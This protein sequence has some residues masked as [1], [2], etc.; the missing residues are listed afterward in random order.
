MPLP[1]SNRAW[2]SRRAKRP[3]RFAPRPSR[4]KTRSRKHNNQPRRRVAR[5]DAS[6][7]RRGGRT[8]RGA[9]VEDGRVAAPPPRRTRRGGGRTRRGAVAEDG[10]ARRYDVVVIGSGIGGL[11]CAG[12]LA[13]AGREVCVLEAHYEFGGCAHEFDVDL[14]GRT[15]P[16]ARLAALGADAPP[17]FKFEAGPSLYSGLSPAASPNPLKHIY[18]MIE[19]EPEWITYR[20]PRGTRRARLS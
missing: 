2:L 11:S 16:S 5:T 1:R 20:P 12:L 18:Q 10:L 19:E 7:R 17:T 6:R 13:A 3:L 9:A 15:V 14:E 8:R 4:S